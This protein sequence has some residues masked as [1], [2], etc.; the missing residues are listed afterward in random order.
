MLQCDDDT[1]ATA[2]TLFRTKHNPPVN[3]NKVSESFLQ[4]LPNLFPSTNNTTAALLDAYHEGTVYNLVTS[5][6]GQADPFYLENIL[7]QDCASSSSALNMVSS[8]K[9]QTTDV[10]NGNLKP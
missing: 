8:P 6:H 3:K 9:N 4:T 2:P 7:R 10:D 1:T 5:K